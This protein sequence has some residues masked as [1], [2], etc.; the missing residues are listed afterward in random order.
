LGK[1]AF[2]SAKQSAIAFLHSRDSRCKSGRRSS[3]LT[4]R[5]RGL[6]VKKTPTSLQANRKKARKPGLGSRDRR[7][8]TSHSGGS[9]RPICSLS[10]P[11]GSQ[12][13]V[14]CSAVM[15]SS[16]SA[17]NRYHR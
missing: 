13:T 17:R 15:K 14:I 1:S 4:L 9:R 5:D 7:S 11:N 16:N 6:H 8:H 10:A 12:Q 3:Q 2:H